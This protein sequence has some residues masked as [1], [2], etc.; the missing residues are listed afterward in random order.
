MGDRA[1]EHRGIPGAR[2]LEQLEQNAA[3]ADLLLAPDEL[4]RLTGEAER[5]DAGRRV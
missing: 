4:A 1:P 3:A 2:S 5:F